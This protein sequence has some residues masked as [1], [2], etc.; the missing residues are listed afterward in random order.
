[1]RQHDSS[2]HTRLRKERRRSSQPQPVAQREL[3][4]RSAALR[5]RLTLEQPVAHVV[6]VDGQGVEHLVAQSIGILA[7]REKKKQRHIG[8]EVCRQ[9]RT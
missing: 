8:R 9:Q 7:T 1:M 2:E 4:G 5:W 6:A 3:L